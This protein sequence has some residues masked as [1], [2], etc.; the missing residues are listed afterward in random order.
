[1]DAGALHQAID[2]L[3]AQDVSSLCDDEVHEL[4]MGLARARCRVDGVMMAALDVWDARRIWSD[5][6][7]KSPSARLAR[8]AN[9]SKSAASIAIRRARALR[10]LPAT[11]AAVTNGEMGAEFVDLVDHASTVDLTVPFSEC[12]PAIVKGC[13]T[14]GYAESRD[15]INRWVDAADPDNAD[16]RAKKRFERRGLTAAGTID[17]LVHLNGLLDAMGGQELLAELQRIESQLYDDDRADDRADHQVRTAQQ[18]RADAL[19]EMARRSAALDTAETAAGT[20]ARVVLTVVLGLNEFE[21][22]CELADGTPLAPGELVPLL[23]RADVERIV[24]GSPDRVLSI[25][26]RRSFPAAVR[27]AIQIRDRRCTHP[28]GC[29]DPA[30]WCDVDHIH[31]HSCGGET[32]EANGRL[33]CRTH[34]RN[35]TLRNRAPA[36]DA[37]R[38]TRP[39]RGWVPRTPNLQPTGHTGGDRSSGDGSSGDGDGDGPAAD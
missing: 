8:E 16:E 2:D 17:G 22:L 20:P 18:R 30:S 7:S 38:T 26:H 37:P 21:R 23:H 19:V 36:A 13:I 27:R 15:A 33:L 3:A 14:S 28:S 24:F 39:P 32:S 5:D 12:E 35:H 1:M 9:W 6:G 10:R 11:A 29:D 4:V 34:N 25:S 31:E